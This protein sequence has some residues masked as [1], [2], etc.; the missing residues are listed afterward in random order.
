[1]VF[2]HPRYGL[3][4]TLQTE[5]DSTL[6]V[7]QFIDVVNGV[8]KNA[9]G[10]GVWIQGEIEGFNGRGKHTHFNIVER[11]GA[12]KARFNLSGWGVHFKKIYR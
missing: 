11:S 12:K 10:A 1:M 7:S 6:S 2:M 4:A 9:F 3:G 5:E 8:L